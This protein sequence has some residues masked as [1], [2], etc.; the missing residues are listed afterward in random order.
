MLRKQGERCSNVGWAER[1]DA[2]RIKIN[3]NIVGG[4]PTASHLL[5]LRQK[6]VTEE[7]ATPVRRRF[8]VPCVAQTV[9]RLRN[10]RFALRQ[11][12]PTTPDRF[13][14]LGGAQ[15]IEKRNP[16]VKIQT[17]SWARCAQLPRKKAWA[18]VPTQKRFTVF[19]FPS[20]VRRLDNW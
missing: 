10:S 2:Q 11:S 9:R 20:P 14:L 4:S 15:G 12:S 5:L 1:S 19:E 18:L 16:K 8:A 13:P 17:R 3:T 7:K 6:K